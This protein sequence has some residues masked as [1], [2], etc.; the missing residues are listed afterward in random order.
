[1]HAFVHQ[2]AGDERVRAVPALPASL[3]A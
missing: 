1:V 2:S 3:Q